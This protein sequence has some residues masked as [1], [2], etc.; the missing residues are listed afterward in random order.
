[1]LKKLNIMA[2]I[3]VLMAA[4]GCSSTQKS[5]D[6]RTLELT[7]K[8]KATPM[9]AELDVAN[10]KALGQAKG[11]VIFKRDLE[12]EAI[13][14]ALKQANGDVLVGVS[15]FYEEV[16][17]TDLTV[18]VVGYPARY[19]NFKPKELPDPKADVLVGGNFFYKDGDNNLSVMVKSTKPDAPKEQ[20]AE[21][22]P[23]EKP[24]EKLQE[25]PQE[26]PEITN[27]PANSLE[28]GIQ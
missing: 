27:T 9:V 13:A 17:K 21:Q 11:K 4:A 7:P 10:K 12:Q 28:E 25:K 2:S 24:Q 19:K 15:Y 18:T 6:L 23:K 5:N 26:K 8:A 3:A 22:K 16:D 1:M 14:K 20:T